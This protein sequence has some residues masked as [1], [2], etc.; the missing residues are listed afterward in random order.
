ML[1]YI[2]SEKTYR[3]SIKAV[4]IYFSMTILKRPAHILN[5]EKFKT[6]R[7]SYTYILEKLIYILHKPCTFLYIF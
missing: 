2:Y 7:H 4:H 1:L 3:H 5:R 6:D